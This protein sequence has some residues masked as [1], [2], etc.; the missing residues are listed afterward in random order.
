MISIIIPVYNLEN[1]I[2]KTLD[3]VLSQTYTDLEILITDDG[4][5]DRSPEIL[6]TY[7]AKDERIKVF[8]QENG[9]AA[10]ARN[11]CLNHMTGEYVV[12]IDGDDLVAPDYIEML[13]RDITVNQTD[14]SI[15]QYDNIFTEDFLTQNLPP[16][17]HTEHYTLYDTKESIYE[18]LY[19]L[20]FDS[21][22]WV[23][24]YK[25]ELFANLRFPLGNVFE[26]FAIIYDVFLRARRI[27][28]SEHTGYYYFNRDDSTTLKGFQ[29]SKMS[30]IDELD[31]LEDKISHLYPEE[32]FR[33]AMC[34]R[35]VR[36][37]FHIYLQIP[38]TAEY[39]NERQRIERNIRSCRRTVLGDTHARRGTKLAL[40]LTYLGF[41]TFYRLK[42][43]KN[44]GK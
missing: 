38:R 9:G 25:S 31:K 23:K 29:K 10:S 17:K 18:L 16:V 1:Y 15:C 5:T 13:Y 42:R 41:G 11:T 7:A 36:G 6:D 28:Y 21:Q 43:L 39:K 12:F 22:M 30:L 19:Q 14:I 4:S 26:D 35:K 2:E 8:H 33:Y 34:S 44:L 37:N 32:K 20:K 40:L 24:I 27:S 3:S